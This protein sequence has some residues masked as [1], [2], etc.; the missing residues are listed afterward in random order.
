MVQSG[1]MKNDRKHVTVV[2][3]LVKI[4]LIAGLTAAAIVAAHKHDL[5]TLFSA[6][7]GLVLAIS[8][9]IV[10]TMVAFSGGLV[11]TPT[12]AYTRHKKAM[13]S[14]FILNLLLFGLVALIYRQ[15]DYTALLITY[16]VS[17]SGYWISLL[18]PSMR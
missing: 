2:Y 12:I 14:R 9:T 15:C 8:P 10:Y 4:Q 13:I 3:Q 17:L 5:N 1:P 6:I 18:L 11:T 7:V 16:I